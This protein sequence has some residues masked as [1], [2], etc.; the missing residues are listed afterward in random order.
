MY[1]ACLDCEN[2][3][4]G[5]FCDFGPIQLLSNS[6]NYCQAVSSVCALKDNKNLCCLYT[7]LAL[8]MESNNSDRAVNNSSQHAA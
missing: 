4:K 1:T 5:A 8:Y 7:V 3:L 6:A 2:C